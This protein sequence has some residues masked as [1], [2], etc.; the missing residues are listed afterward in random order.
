[1]KCYIINLERSR[2]R[3][4]SVVNQFKNLDLPY[5]RLEAVDSEK[6][7]FEDSKKLKKVT[8]TCATKTELACNLSHLKA[9]QQIAEN[10]DDYG[11]IL[12]DDVILSSNCKYFFTNTD[13]IPKDTTIIKLDVGVKK[14]LF[15][16]K[17]EL[18]KK[19][20]CLYDL[21]TNDYSAAGYLISKKTAIDIIDKLKKT[22]LL[23]DIF[24]FNYT[25]GC[26][27]ELNPR[28]LY[29]AILD[30]KVTVSNIEHINRSM[31]I[32][33][34]IIRLPKQFGNK[35]YIK[36][37]LFPKHYKWTHRSFLK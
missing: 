31:S 14:A 15:A 30:I 8:F 23:V 29:P 35:R 26:A 9:L 12:E 6:L 34:S 1:M 27:K 4:H 18:S 22:N 20:Y 3:W 5:E 25:E 21:L 28:Q 32:L 33:R 2:D 17:Q 24:L 10:E 16:N 13:W 19:P 7:I 11:I 37:L 36:R